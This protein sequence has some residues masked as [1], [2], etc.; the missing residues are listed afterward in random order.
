MLIKK[1]GG[2]KFLYFYIF[3]EDSLMVACLQRGYML[4]D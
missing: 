2:S 3:I 1:K 4:L